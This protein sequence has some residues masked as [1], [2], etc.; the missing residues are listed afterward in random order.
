MNIKDKMVASI[1]YT[2]KNDQGEVIDTSMGE[3][4]E[5]LKFLFGSGMII[6]GLESAL[7]GK[8][9]GDTFK[10]TVPP[11]EAY[12]NPREDMVQEVPASDLAHLEGLAV[13]AALQAE[14]DDGQSMNLVVTK[15]T[16]SHVTLDGNHPLAGE[17]L[18]FEGEVKD[19]REA[20]ETELEH[21][22]SH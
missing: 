15:M 11:E 13:G 8:A 18:H 1:D 17:T 20:T 12:G 10:V 9:K 5:P 3:G 4:G 14:L 21:G 2:L 22:H 7:M 6:K 16:D 19:V